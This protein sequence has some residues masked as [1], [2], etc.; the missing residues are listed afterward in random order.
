[1]MLPGMLSFLSTIGQFDL[2]FERGL[3]NSLHPVFRSQEPN[4]TSEDELAVNN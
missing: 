2:T 3:L 4:N 1:M